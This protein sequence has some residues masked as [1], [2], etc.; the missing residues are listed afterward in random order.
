IQQ[1]LLLPDTTL[2]TMRLSPSSSLETLA[3]EGIVGPGLSEAYF[4]ARL[5][6]V[7][8]SPHMRNVLCAEAHDKGWF[9]QSGVV[10]VTLPSPARHINGDE[11]MA[12]Y[13][14]DAARHRASELAAI[15]RNVAALQARR[16]WT[17]TGKA[18]TYTC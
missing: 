13:L 3:A 14:D 17:L 10:E 4:C 7:L 12:P 5:D 11:P 16:G 8:Q 1:R 9:A 2:D 15:Q 6:K 18:E